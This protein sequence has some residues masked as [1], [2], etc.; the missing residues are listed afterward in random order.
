S[1]VLG[2]P[3]RKRV[4]QRV[5][6]RAPRHPITHPR[7]PV[8]LLHQILQTPAPQPT[9]TVVHQQR[10]LS[11]HL[12]PEPRTPRGQIPPQQRL[13]RPLDRQ[14]PLRAALT[15]HPHPPLTGPTTDRIHPQRQHLR[16]PHP[17]QQRQR[18]HRQVPLRPRIPRLTSPLRQS[19]QQLLRSVLTP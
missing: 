17:R 4:T 16:G 19:P 6:Q 3:R 13:Q 14:H 5:H 18:Q 2:Q 15:Q 12:T 10:L 8:A 7:V 11:T 1:P 9:T